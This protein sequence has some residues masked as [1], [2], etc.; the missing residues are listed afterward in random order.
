MTATGAY[1][2]ATYTFIYDCNANKAY[3]DGAQ[4]FREPFEYI[5]TYD[6][7][8]GDLQSYNLYTCCLNNPINRKDESR[9]LS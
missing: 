6:S 7:N 4:L 3:F 5:Y 8:G 9:N 2:K 1:T